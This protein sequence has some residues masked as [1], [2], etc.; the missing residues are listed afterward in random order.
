MNNI[1]IVGASYLQ[2]PLVNRA[3]E[4]GY[5]THV[6]AWESGAVVKTECDKY[7]PISIVDLDSIIEICDSLNPVG[8]VSIASD[9]AARTVRAL[10]K[11]YNMPCNSDKSEFMTANKAHMREAFKIAGLPSPQYI[12]LSNEQRIL[13]ELEPSLVFPVIVKPVDR[14]GSRGVTRVDDIAKLRIAVTEAFRE[15]FCKEVIV[16]SF[17]AGTEASVESISWQGEHSILAITDKVTTGAPHY[18]ELEH[19]QPSVLSEDVQKYIRTL[20]P[21][22]LDVLDI[23][24]GAA[25]SEVIVDAHGKVWITEIGARMGGDFIGSHLVH[26]STGYDYM[27]GVVEIATNTFHNIETSRQRYAGVKFLNPAVGQV[28]AIESRGNMFPFIVESEVFLEVGQMTAP[29]RHSGERGA[30]FIYR[31]DESRVQT[32]VEDIVR[33]TYDNVI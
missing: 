12:V 13:D 10:A 18:V 28:A 8:V 2:R 9:L 11:R 3:K 23:Q 20:I 5:R 7:Y 22:A 1:I 24:Y 17:I 33:I 21:M 25:H 27:Q 6:F 4:M 14:S 32:R 29:A 19:H 31:S 15:S 16:E 26:M 30:Y